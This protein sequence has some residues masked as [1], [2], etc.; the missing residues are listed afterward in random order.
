[1][2]DEISFSLFAMGGWKAPN[3]DGLSAIFY[4]NN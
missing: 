2:D 4:Q 3:L 1:M